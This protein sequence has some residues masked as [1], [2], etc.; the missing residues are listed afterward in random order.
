MMLLT[1]KVMPHLH[2]G[3]E[4]GLCISSWLY[5]LAVDMAR[6]HEVRCEPHLTKHS[7]ITGGSTVVSNRSELHFK[8]AI[9]PGI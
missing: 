6:S 5:E 1:Q 3:T 7:W 4:Y 8:T 2:Q 9:E